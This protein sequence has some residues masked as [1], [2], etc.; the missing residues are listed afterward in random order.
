MPEP[1]SPNTQPAAEVSEDDKLLALLAYV[2]GLCLIPYART[3]RSEFVS[4]HVRLGMTL[5]VIE[6]FAL[7]LRYLRVV[8]DVI[9][10]LCVIAALAGIVHVVRG[11]SFSLPYL[12][13]LFSKKL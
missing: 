6:V 12:S 3:D 2:P 4:A 8:W 9:I 10:L 13:D 5:F 11:R 7:I 1:T